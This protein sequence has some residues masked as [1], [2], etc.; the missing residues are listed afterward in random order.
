MAAARSK[1]YPSWQHDLKLIQDDNAFQSH[2]KSIPHSKAYPRWQLTL[3]PGQ[4][5][6]TLQSL[7]KSTPHSKACPSL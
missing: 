1:A 3:K 7:P 4:V 6:S 5:S 2:P